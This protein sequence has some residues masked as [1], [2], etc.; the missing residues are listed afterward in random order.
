MIDVTRAERI[1]RSA[2]AGQTEKDGTPYEQ[3]LERVVALVPTLIDGRFVQSALAVAWLHDILE[4]TNFT[5]DDLRREGFEGPLVQSIE[6]L[7]RRGDFA[8]RPFYQR[9][10]DAILTSGNVVA[11]VVKEADLIDHLRPNCPPSLRARY[12]YALRTIQF[13]RQRHVI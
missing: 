8:Q 13:Y 9:Y 1:A 12:E 6:L 5:A 10:V 4:D 7:T 11:I 3:H 2:H